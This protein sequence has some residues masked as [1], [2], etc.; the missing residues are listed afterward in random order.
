VYQQ[1]CRSR[2]AVILSILAFGWI[3]CGPM[4]PLPGGHLSGPVAVAPTSWSFSDSH[5][6]IQLETGRDPY[7]VNLWGVGVGEHFYLASGRGT[8][9]R[10]AK[11]IESDAN[12]R[13]RI[14]GTVYELRAVR[15]DA[16]AER[17]LFL[18]A[19]KSKYDWEPSEDETERALLYRLDP[20]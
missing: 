4:G 12:V 18:E 14:D 5:E 8:D 11:N 15:V 13:L 7:S 20:R 9:A 2:R 19:V 16:E 3:G 6:T 10:W 17:L 1:S